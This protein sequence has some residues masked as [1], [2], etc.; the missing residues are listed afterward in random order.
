MKKLPRQMLVMMLLCAVVAFGYSRPFININLSFLGTTRTTSLSLATVFEDSDSPLGNLNMGQ[1]D[2]SDMA[3]G[4]SFMEDVA[5]RIILSV[6]AYLIAFVMLLAIFI[7]TI[8]GKLKKVKIAMLALA[9]SLI[10]V[11]G[12]VIMTVPG[13][14]TDTLANRLGFLALFIDVGELLSINLGIGFWLILTAF[15]SMLLT[16]VYMIF[17]KRKVQHGDAA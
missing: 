17:N 4:D 3:G 11:S 12:A 6:G 16:E 10:I 2:L 8:V 13:V 1:S 5:G 9:S 14:I 15:L 7:I